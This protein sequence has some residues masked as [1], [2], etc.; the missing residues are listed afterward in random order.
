[1]ITVN[2]AECQ[3]HFGRYQD[4]AMSEPVAITRDGRD[5]VVMISADEYRR[6]KRRAREVL[7]AGQL[8]D[9][10]LAAIAR[11]EMDPRHA[12]LDKELE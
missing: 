2:A 1:M 6:L 7:R 3:R 9:A 11:A 8:S 4:Q 12:D 5:C 10:D